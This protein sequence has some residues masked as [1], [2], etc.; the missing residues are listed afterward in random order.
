MRNM[1]A[2]LAMV[3]T[4]ASPLTA[5]NGP[6][7][8][9]ASEVW[10]IDGTESGEPFFDLR[11]YLIGRDGAL[12]VLEFKDQIIRRFDGNGKAL[13]TVGRKGSGPGELRN[14]NGML[15]R[16]DGSVWVNDPGNGRLTEFGAGGKFA[17]QHLVPIR[18]YGY[19]WD[20]WLDRVS[21]ELVDPFINQVAGGASR[22]DWR[23]WSGAGVIRDTVPMPTCASGRIAPGMSIKAETKGK[24]NMYSAYPFATGGGSAPDGR[25]AVWCASPASTRVSL[26][27]IGK[28]DTLVQTRMELPHIPV[29]K[30]ERDAA[31]ATIQKQIAAYATNDFDPTKIP[32]TR[33][34]IALLTV[35]DDGRLW[36]QHAAAFGD[37]TVTFDIH[38][39][40]GKHLGR[41]R[42]PHR[43]SMEGLAIR[44]RGDDLW[45][46]LRDVDDV[47]GIARYRIVR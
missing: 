12:W 30:V 16:S 35:D 22:M 17:Q 42:I 31:I 44:A 5:Q 45:I 34:A 47:I 32:S 9:R 43:P 4:C 40:A 23:R 26:V 39:R 24:G 36:V 41:L 14:A 11:D 7:S 33:S 38:D 18:G 25:G 1:R 6:T 37:A 20:A 13:A 19:R 10:R 2:L 46:A 28:N 29:G 8:W 21:G 15:L 3:A 27:R